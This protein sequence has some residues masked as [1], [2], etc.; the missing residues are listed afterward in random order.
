[1]I[2]GG[3]K[4]AKILIKGTH[5][6]HYALIWNCCPEIKKAMLISTL[7]VNKGGKKLQEGKGGVFNKVDSPS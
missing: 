2:Y 4:K 5:K 1:M 6:E 3:K 7:V